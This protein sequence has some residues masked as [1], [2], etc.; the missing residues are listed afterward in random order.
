MFRSL[1]VPNYRR[2]FS[3]SAVGNI[4]IWTMRTGQAWVV[5]HLSGGSGAAL[6]L[7]TF[8]Q[9]APTM[10][11]SV[12]AGVLAD[13]FDKATLLA[14]SQGAIGVIGISLGVLDLTGSLTLAW[15][16]VLS[17]LLGLV[18]AL[19]APVRQTFSSELVGPQ[20]VVNAVGLNSASF[21]VAR[22]VGPVASALLITLWGTSV[23]FLLTGL[24]S[25][26][27][28]ASLVRIDRGALHRERRAPG[29]TS[30]VAGFRYVAGSPVLIG[31]TVLVALGN[32]TGANSLQVLLPIVA[33]QVH[34]GGALMFGLLCAGLAVGGLAGALVASA[35]S[36]MPRLR[37][38]VG[39]ALAFGGSLL[40][41]SATTS[42]VA[43]GICLALVGACF[44][45]LVVMVNTTVQLTPPPSLRGRVVA[46][47]TMFFLGGGAL[48]SPLLGLLSDHVGPMR[49]VLTTGV[50]VVLGTVLVTLA[51]W[52]AR[53]REPAP[54]PRTE[55][56]PG[57]APCR[58]APPR[59]R[60]RRRA[61]VIHGNVP[62][63]TAE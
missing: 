45:N 13:R 36:G 47:Y 25:V 51:L 14:I 33:T 9:F 28:V 3:G 5:L 60:P 55:P 56:A 8:L 34:G 16:Y 59:R 37:R 22:L 53:R 41:V 4:G 49:A 10:L 35:Q 57:G 39:V 32:A 17:G 50:T 19:D 7:V 38:V 40:L 42:P 54:E 12:V 31:L 21:N 46:V 44:M 29:R 58:P 27:I 1:G 11:L 61:G 48:G 23:V 20:D 62:T 6:G 30:W 24:C 2:Y 15:V 52:H 18:T 26:A 63:P 43:L